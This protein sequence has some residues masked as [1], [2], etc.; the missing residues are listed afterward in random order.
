M[1][2]VWGIGAFPLSLVD[3]KGGAHT[4]LSIVPV[5]IRE[6]FSTTTIGNYGSYF[7]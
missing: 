1:L 6:W 3:G 2:R 5:S 4:V 7:K